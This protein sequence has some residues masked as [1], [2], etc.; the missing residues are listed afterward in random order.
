MPRSCRDVP[1]RWRSGRGAPTTRKPL[2]PQGPGA[3]SRDL[4]EQRWLQMNQA[5]QVTSSELL[6]QL[7]REPRSKKEQGDCL[8][9]RNLTYG[10]ASPHVR[11]ATS[12]SRSETAR[13][14]Q[15]QEHDDFKAVLG[16]NVTAPNTAEIRKA[17]SPSAKSLPQETGEEKQNKPREG[18]KLE[19]P[20]QKSV[21]LKT[22]TVE[23]ISETN[24]WFFG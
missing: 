18:R 14:A 11:E 10:L 19:K 1:G 3:T 22:E 21:T 2:G 23:K 16:G 15:N 20:E 17:S 9:W 8:P 4:R 13:Q 24:T 7:S 6:N 12:G 5:D